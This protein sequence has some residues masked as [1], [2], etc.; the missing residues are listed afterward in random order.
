[1]KVIVTGGAGFIGSWVVDSL[2][3]KG[4]QVT[5]IDNLSSGNKSNVNHK[6][7]LYEIDLLG[8]ID[9]IFENEKPE[10]VFHFAAQINVRKSIEDPK[11]DAEINILGTLN[12]LDKCVKH[13]VKKI[14]FSSSGGAIYG[15]K[16]VIPTPEE[17]ETRPE[18]PYG[19]AKLTIELYLEFYKKV[20]GL[21]YVAL[22]Y[23]NVYGPRQSS[24]GEAG[25]VDIFFKS[26]ENGETPVIF[27][28]GEQTRD[29]VYVKDVA[30]CNI[31]AMNLSGIFNVG[32]GIETS[33]N[34]IFEKIA[35]VSNAP[36]IK[37]NGAKIEGELL[38]S[39]LD[40]SKLNKIVGW[41]PKYNLDSGLMETYEFF[42]S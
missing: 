20:F 42:K 21:D 34:E 10:Y 7:K 30:H 37:R 25:V 40:C 2:I 16:E 12:L 27:G 14:I 41:S 19:I 13:R 8:D 22:R 24:K 23:S 33:V 15:G 4:H 35:K 36:M 11:K 31:L 29:Y 1:M 28:D 18:S 39:A 32:T 17:S 3:E 38:R 26:L 9:S 6:A 5:V